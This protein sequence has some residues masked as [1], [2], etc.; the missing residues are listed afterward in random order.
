MIDFK[1]SNINNIFNAIAIKYN[2]M[3]HIRIYNYQCFKL[4]LSK[5]IKGN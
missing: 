2:Q 3:V 5:Y 4:L 1:M